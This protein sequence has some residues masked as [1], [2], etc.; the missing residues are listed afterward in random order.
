MVMPWRTITGAEPDTVKAVSPVLNGGRE[1]TYSNATRLA[2]TQLPRSRFQR[3]L[4]PGVMFS[5]VIK[6]QKKLCSIAPGDK[7]RP[8]VLLDRTRRCLPA[9]V[10]V[11]G[12]THSIGVLDSAE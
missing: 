3:R 4:T 1:E 7:T 2:P 5:V 8:S 9:N 11:C 6:V 10:A 12:N